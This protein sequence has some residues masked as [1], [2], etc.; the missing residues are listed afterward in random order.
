M[1]TDWTT[2][3]VRPELAGALALLQRMTQEPSSIDAAFV[4]DL[5][6][7]GL[8][9]P[10]IE[11]A[12]T[13]AF[14]YAIINRAADVFAFP[15]PTQEQASGIAGR[16]SR[17]NRLLRI[18]PPSPLFVKTDDG[19]WR[20]TDVEAARTQL[21]DT[22]GTVDPRVRRDVEAF[23]ATYFGAERPAVDLDEPLLSFVGRVAAFPAA[24]DDALVE[25]L[26]E[27]GYDDEGIFEITMAASMGV[28][29]AGLEPLATLL[30]PT[31]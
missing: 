29:C 5:H 12:S 7:R 8:S 2:A 27:A 3:P 25:S 18:H 9:T 15:V 19:A 16:L 13:V 22:S 28:A 17:I 10:A 30:G 23:A 14:R 20:P 4:A 24:V 1:L 21:L 26:R 6:D 11:A 31:L